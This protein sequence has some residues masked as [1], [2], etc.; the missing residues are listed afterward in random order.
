MFIIMSTGLCIDLFNEIAQKLEFSYD[1]YE[2]T[3]G[4]FGSLNAD[5]T[6]N[7]AIRELI[8]KVRQ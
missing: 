3:D 4:Y 5:G 1:L 6:W 7:G 2:S 8:E